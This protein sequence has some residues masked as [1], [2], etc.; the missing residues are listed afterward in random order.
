MATDSENERLRQK[1]TSSSSGPS[2]AMM[3]TANSENK[4]LKL[5]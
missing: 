5:F 1:L 2:L 4:I 3:R